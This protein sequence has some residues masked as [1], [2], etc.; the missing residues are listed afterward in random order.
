MSSWE[1]EQG[2]R[3]TVPFLSAEPAADLKP[4]DK[5]FKQPN[6]MTAA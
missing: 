2:I 6:V 1:Y 3:V 4:Q 5:N